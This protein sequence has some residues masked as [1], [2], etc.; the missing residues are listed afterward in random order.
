MRPLVVTGTGLVAVRWPGHDRVVASI[1]VDR[2][3]RS[4]GLLAVADPAGICTR[5]A[6]RLYQSNRAVDP[7][8]QD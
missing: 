7:L 5:A 8:S 3:I 2:N 6:A 1:G 4:V